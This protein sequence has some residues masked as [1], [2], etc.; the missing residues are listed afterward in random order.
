MQFVRMTE[1]AQFAVNV[2]QWTISPSCACIAAI[3][4]NGIKFLGWRKCYIYCAY[5]PAA[6]LSEK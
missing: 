2:E 1:N 5:K 4:C 3:K 6:V